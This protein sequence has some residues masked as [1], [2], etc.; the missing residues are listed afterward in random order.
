MTA[1]KRASYGAAARQTISAARDHDYPA[2]RARLSLL[3]GIV[4]LRQDQP[5]VAA[6]EFQQA[7]TQAEQQL[8]P[9]SGDYQAL[10]TKALALCGLALTTEPGK[11]AEAWTVFRAAR[12]ITSADGIVRRTLA[13]FDVLAAADRR[14]ILAGTRQAV[15]AA[16]LSNDRGTG[17]GPH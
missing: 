4:W 17:P 2:D 1:E 5:T 16:D 3:S 12:A 11:A 15:E 13:L 7:L 9:A 8:E 6:S 14:G 10:D